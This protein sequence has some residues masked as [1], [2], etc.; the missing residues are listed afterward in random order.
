ME[1]CEPGIQW[2][3]ASNPRRAVATPLTPGRLDCRSLHRGYP[4]RHIS[5]HSVACCI[6]CLLS[7]TGP[8]PHIHRNAPTTNT[9]TLALLPSPSMSTCSICLD[10]Q[11]QPI[12]LPCGHIFCYPCIV[13]VIDA[14]KSYTTL[15][16][17]PTCRNPYTVV[18]IDPALVPAY[19]RPHIMPSIRK[20]YFDT[21]EKK[22]AA[23]VE[24]ADV[25]FIDRARM[26]AE[27]AALRA[28]CG[29]WR[30]RAEVHAAATLGLLG[31]VRQARD[32]AIQIK[33]ERDEMARRYN[34]LKRKMEDD[35]YT[36]VS[37]FSPPAR[38]LSYAFMNVPN[39]PGMEGKHTVASF[40]PPPETP[41]IPWALPS[42][43]I[44]DGAPPLKRR[45]S[46]SPEASP[47]RSRR[48][49][50]RAQSPLAESPRT[51]R[52]SC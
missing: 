9:N 7:A 18:N 52:N 24:N 20:L 50:P 11:K 15:H 35:E 1:A 10:E 32:C 37:S 16:C 48:E 44:L 6:K 30:K 42:A 26:Q 36:Q 27:N 25:E 40:T 47:K 5:F 29:L 51:E 13:R 14:V 45:R 8:S 46:A 28:N 38:K 3:D 17:C 34:A 23:R 39:L 43:N 19:L 2:G 4:G 33:N 22:P 49:S 21:D 12:S 41:R 31:L